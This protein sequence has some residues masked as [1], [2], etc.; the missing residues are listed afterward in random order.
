VVDGLPA[1]QQSARL[2]CMKKPQPEDETLFKLTVRLPRAL[3]DEAKIRAIREG[4]TLQEIAAIALTAYLRTP[5]G[6]GGAR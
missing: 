5:I 2:R 1:S 6:K 3:A 4:K